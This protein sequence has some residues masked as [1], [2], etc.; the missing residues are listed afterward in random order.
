MSDDRRPAFL[1][2]E[3]FRF[4]RLGEKWRKPR[5]MHSQDEPP[6]QYRPPIVSIGYRGPQRSAVCIPPDSKR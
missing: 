1:R 5:G 3:W 4:A 2:Q 6:L